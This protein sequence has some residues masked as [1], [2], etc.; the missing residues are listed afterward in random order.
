[1]PG[2]ASRRA[3]ETPRRTG[4][5]CPALTCRRRAAAP[6]AASARCC[7]RRAARWSPTRL[8]PSAGRFGPAACHHPASAKSAARGATSPRNARRCSV[9]TLSSSRNAKRRRPKPRSLLSH[10]ERPTT[11][12]RKS[13]SPSCSAPQVAADARGSQAWAQQRKRHTGCVDPDACSE[14]ARTAFLSHRH[15]SFCR[16]AS[17]RRR[18]ARAKPLTESLPAWPWGKFCTPSALSLCVRGRGR[19]RTGR[20]DL[21]SSKAL[22]SGPGVARSSACDAAACVRRAARRAHQGVAGNKPSHIGGKFFSDAHS[23]LATGPITARC[24]PRAHPHCMCQLR[25]AATQA[26]LAPPRA[27]IACCCLTSRR[28]GCAFCNLYAGGQ[29]CGAVG[30]SEGNEQLLLSKPQPRRRLALTRR[31]ADEP[32]QAERRASAGQRQAA[33]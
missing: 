22:R 2:C 25:R 9:R 32:A 1:M 3:P 14:H 7:A 15:N 8:P 31:A 26:Q 17:L 30:E 20:P 28:R 11:N 24:A 6:A 33:Q 18:K 23:R 21:K 12:S 16:N 5:E 13:I 27:Q 29:H 4:S 19:P 10:D